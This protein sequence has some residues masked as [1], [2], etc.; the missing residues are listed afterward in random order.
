MRGG[1][2]ST[3]GRAS[4]FGSVRT[5]T[6]PLRSARPSSTRWWRS[7]ATEVRPATRSRYSFMSMGL[8]LGI[9][10]GIVVLAVV[11]LPRAHYEAV[12]QIDPTEPIVAAQRVASYHIY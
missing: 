5:S 2:P 3:T 9:V 1:F 12:K 10:L 8:S 4:A 11:L 7:V 6:T